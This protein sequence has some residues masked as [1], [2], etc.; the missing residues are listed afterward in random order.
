MKKITLQISDE[1]YEFA[2]KQAEE[3]E[4]FGTADYLNGLLNMALLTA[5]V[6]ADEFEDMP[7]PLPLVSLTTEQ[8]QIMRIMHENIKHDPLAEVEEDEGGG[9]RLTPDREDDDFDDDIPF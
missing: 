6:D 9:M 8:H 4:F 3:D 5:V 2:R 1:F 7:Y